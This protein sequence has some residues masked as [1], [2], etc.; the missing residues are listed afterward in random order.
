[1]KMKGIVGGGWYLYSPGSLR[2]SLKKAVTVHAYFIVYGV[3][4][5]F[6]FVWAF[7]GLLVVKLSVPSDI[8]CTTLQKEKKH[9]T[10]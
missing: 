4:C 3:L 1:M 8:L 7:L 6:T 10:V 5:N 9:N 2:R